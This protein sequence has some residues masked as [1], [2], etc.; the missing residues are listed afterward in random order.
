M[1]LNDLGLVVLLSVLVLTLASYGLRKLEK[2][3]KECASVMQV[4][5]EAM[6]AEADTLAHV[7]AGTIEAIVNA[8]D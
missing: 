3:H 1:R 2:S 5:E 6:E 8:A 7:P 4:A